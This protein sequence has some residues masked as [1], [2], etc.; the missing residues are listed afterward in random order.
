MGCHD[1][2]GEEDRVD[3][4][5]RAEADEIPVFTKEQALTD[6][7]HAARRGRAR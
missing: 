6:T 7:E 3:D 4:R 1:R 2:H 5:G